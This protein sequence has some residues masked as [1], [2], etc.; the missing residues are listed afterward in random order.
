M[1]PLRRVG[2]LAALW[3]GVSVA[4]ITLVLF[5]LGPMLQQRDQRALLARYRVTVSNAANEP[6]GVPGLSPEPV[7]PPEVGDPVGIVEIGALKSQDVVIEGVGASQTSKGPGHV[8]GTAG[9]GQP[10]NSVI[11]A[12]HAGY[13]GA[14]SHL[15]RLQRGDEIVV[16]TT[17]GQSVY[18]VSDVNHVSITGGDGSPDGTVTAAADPSANAHLTAASSG[19]AKTVKTSIDTMFGSSPDDRLTLVTASSHSPWDT[20]NAIEVVAKLEGKPF[21]PTPQQSRST[22]ETGTHGDHDV[23]AAVILALLAFV[24]VIAGSVVLFHKLRFRTAYVL[25]IA[26]LVAITVITGETLVRLLPAWT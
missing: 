3:I 25:S 19:E 1:P 24:G 9:I 13:G 20:S 4:G 15:G 7:K 16:T 18:K 5:A 23:L 8:P 2:A 12:R 21:E 6:Q 10:G 22:S 11:V 17:Q 26:P 14:F